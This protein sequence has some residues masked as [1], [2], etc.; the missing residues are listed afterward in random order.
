VEVERSAVY[1]AEPVYSMLTGTVTRGWE[2]A[3]K[4][5]PAGDLV[6]GVDGPAVLNWDLL[7]DGRSSCHGPRWSR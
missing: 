6:L 7:L 3:V 1:D 2:A 4:G 5:L